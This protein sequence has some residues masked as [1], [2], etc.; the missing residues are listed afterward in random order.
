MSAILFEKAS[1]KAKWKRTNQ[2]KHVF[3]KLKKLLISSPLLAFLDFSVR[4]REPLAVVFALRRFCHYL[5][6]DKTFT[7]ITDHKALEEVFNR[8]DIHGRLARWMDFIAE[9]KFSIRYRA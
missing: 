3:L 2:M 7:V 6:S 8:K 5:L 9:N 4:E 1:A